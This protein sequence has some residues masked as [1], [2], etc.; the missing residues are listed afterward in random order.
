MVVTRKILLCFLLSALLF[1]GIVILT[2]SEFLY[3]GS[4]VDGYTVVL[5]FVVFF[6][7]LFL[8][9]YFFL[10]LHPAKTTP[11]EPLA[12]H[13][14][15]QLEELEPVND[16]PAPEIIPVT[17][18]EILSMRLAFDDD[19]VSALVD[20]D[21]MEATAGGAAPL[22]AVTGLGRGFLF[23]QPF[24]FVPGNPE[25]LYK[26]EQETG[27][28]RDAVYERDGIHYVNSAAADIDKNMEKEYNNDFAQLV[29]SVVGI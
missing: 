17:P 11:K 18:P 19:A 10:N 7:T 29:Q 5:T 2:L 22:E 16:L 20:G 28:S 1:T 27:I 3:F 23:R 26:A 21:V 13:V 25:L 6:L 9:I 14:H 15:E 4:I 8:T 24:A 12:V